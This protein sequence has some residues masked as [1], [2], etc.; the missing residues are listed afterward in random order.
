[1]TQ[2][3]RRVQIK[4]RGVKTWLP[5]LKESLLITCKMTLVYTSLPTEKVGVWKGNIFREIPRQR[6]RVA[7]FRTSSEKKAGKINTIISG[8][9]DGDIPYNSLERKKTCFIS[10]RLCIPFYRRVRCLALTDGGINW[11]VV[12]KQSNLCTS[13][14]TTFKISFTFSGSRYAEKKNWMHLLIFY[15]EIKK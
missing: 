6:K 5:D 4:I 3:K 15:M 7:S 11:R 10:N 2:I 13:E 9:G 8:K 14:W 1:M 12:K